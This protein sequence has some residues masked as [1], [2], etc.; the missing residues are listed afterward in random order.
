MY[1]HHGHF[2]SAS[3]MLFFGGGFKEG[4][5][6]G[7]TAPRHPMMPVENPVHIT[8]VYA[9]I[10]KAL[11]I[12]ADTYHITENRPFYVTKDGDGQAIDGLLA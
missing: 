8:D 9:T 7:K 6:Y 1:G 10:Y 4:S 12:P 5:V 3:S 11:G 2:S